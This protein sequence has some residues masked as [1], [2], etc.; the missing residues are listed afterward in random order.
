MGETHKIV[1]FQFAG[2]KITE[3]IYLRLF[4]VIHQKVTGLFSKEIAFFFLRGISYES[5]P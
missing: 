4:N 3:N 2:N 5:A 1:K